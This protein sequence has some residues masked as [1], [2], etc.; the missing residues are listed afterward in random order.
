VFSLIITIISIAL[1][2][3]LAIATIY[4]GGNIVKQGKAR[5]HAATVSTQ[6]QQ[7]MGAAQ[8]FRSTHGRWPTDLNELVTAKL[9]KSIPTAPDLADAQDVYGVKHA[10]AATP[11]WETITPGQPYYWIHNAVASPVCQE[12]NQ[13]S[14]G[15]NGIHQAAIPSL[16]VQCFGLPMGRHTVVIGLPGNTA[17]RPLEEVLEEADPSLPTDPTGG[18]WVTPPSGDGL[19]PLSRYLVDFGLVTVGDSV[20]QSVT[21]T[22]RSASPVTVSNISGLPAEVVRATSGAGVCGPNGFTL[23]PGGSCSISLTYSPLSAGPLL[24]TI[25]VNSNYPSRPAID[26]AIGGT[27]VDALMPVSTLSTSA[28]AFGDL[29]IASGVAEQAVT[30]QNTGTA[31]LTVGTATLTGDADYSLASPVAASCPAPLAPLQTCALSVRLAP[32]ATGPKNG[33]LTITTDAAQSPQSVGLSG[34]GI[35]LPSPLAGSSVDFGS[36]NV[37]TPVTRTLALTNHSNRTL[38]VASITG[39]P[40]GVTRATSGTGVCGPNGFTLTSGAS[41][42]IS[43]TYSPTAAGSLANPVVT[44]N[45]DYPETPTATFTLQ[46]TGNAVVQ[47]PLASDTLDFGNVTVGSTMYRD[48]A[49]RNWS[50]TSSMTVTSITGM[51]ATVTR[52]AGSGGLCGADGFVL[53]ANAACVLRFTFTPTDASALSVPITVNSNY[54]GMNAA[55]FTA[56]GQGLAHS[57]IAAVFPGWQHT[58]V[59]KVDGNLMTSGYNGGGSGTGGGGQLGNGNNSVNRTTF[60]PSYTSLPGQV[61]GEQMMNVVSATA[62]GGN[63]GIYDRTFALKSDGTLWAVGTETGQ[64]GNG[65]TTAQSLNTSFIQVATNVRKVVAAPGHTVILKNDDTMWGAGTGNFFGTNST[66]TVTEF[67]QVASNVKDVAV[68]P[69]HT[70]ML[71]N[72]N[73]VYVSGQNSNGALGLGTTNNVMVLTEIQALAGA[74]AIGAANHASFVV[75]ANDQLWATGLNTNGQLGMGNTTT[76]TTFAVVPSSTSPITGVKAIHGGQDHVALLKN[77]NSVWVAGSNASGQLGMGATTRSTSFVQ[78]ATGVR[79]VAVGYHNTF[80]TYPNN[81]TFAAGRNTSGEMGLGDAVNKT[82]FVQLP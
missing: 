79:S 37:G 70:I 30:I 19:P 36:T 17:T 53:A 39:L 82:S 77:D 25:T 10:F 29:I 72:D 65:G 48:I 13:L 23:A 81:T 64:F 41:C 14:R 58:A 28:L 57:P 18:G 1:V 50:T 45:S 34:R 22:N 3:A 54:A 5:A 12:V 75:M 46:G 20:T 71:T 16:A 31:P 62:M 69:S 40:A 4:Y 47:S 21:L 43:L 15:D 11:T 42:N 26:F 56:K 7:I 73:R 78:V 6:G 24:N 74:K 35:A 61:L 49:L 52:L 8:L 66:A 27:A 9:L 67:T 76:R 68:A 38:T 33:N 55:T 63:A 2:A 32:S 60:Q 44:V 80:I 51:P 59:L